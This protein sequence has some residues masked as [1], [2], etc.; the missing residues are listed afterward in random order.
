MLYYVSKLLFLDSFLIES[1]IVVVVILLAVLH[2]TYSETR[3]KKTTG[4]DR[5]LMMSVGTAISRYTV[6]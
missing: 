6:I 5:T 3:E 2:T 4:N 1:L